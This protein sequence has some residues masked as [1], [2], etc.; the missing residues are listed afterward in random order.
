MIFGKVGAIP[1]IFCIFIFCIFI[2]IAAPAPVFAY[3]VS[4]IVVE[5]G[6]APEGA[7][8]E[9]SNLWE[10]GLMD[11]FFDAGHI[12]SNAHT[13]RV[14][15]EVL[16]DFPDELQGDFDEARQGGVDFFVMALLDYRASGALSDA[17]TASR[18]VFLKVFRVNPYQKVYEQG[19]SGPVRDE[20]ARAKNAARSILPHLRDR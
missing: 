13:I 15:H 14:D 17:A 7:G 1:V 19:Y 8:L 12:V 10:N 9:S 3:T 6:P 2:G 18:Q 11:V 5:T 16:K 4:F 20:L